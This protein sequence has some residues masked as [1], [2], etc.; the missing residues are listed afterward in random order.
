[1]GQTSVEYLGCLTSFMH[2]PIALRTT[3]SYRKSE[4]AVPVPITETNTLTVTVTMTVRVT[5]VTT[6]S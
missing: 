2:A 6:I 1:M 5:R 4:L 3:V